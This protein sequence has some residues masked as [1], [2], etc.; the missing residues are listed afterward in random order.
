MRGL[1]DRRRVLIIGWDGL[2]PD[3]ITPEVTPGLY[4]L[5]QRGAVAARHYAA[6]P[7]E[8]RV[9]AATLATGCWPGRHGIV[10]NEFY[11]RE[12]AS[13][14]NTGSHEHLALIT[15]Y[16]EPVQSAPTLSERLAEHGLKTGISSAGSPGSALMWDPKQIGPV[17]NVFVEFGDPHTREM[18][19]AL[20]PQPPRRTPNTPAD[21]YAARAVTE[22]YLP[23]EAMALCVLWLNDPDHSQHLCGLGSP[24]AVQSLRDCDGVLEEVLSAIRRRGE[25][26]RTDIIICSDHGFSTVVRERELAQLIEEEGLFAGLDDPIA[27]V[28]SYG[29]Y[30]REGADVKPVVERLQAAPWCGTLLARRPIGLEGLLPLGEAWNGHLNGRAPDL[31]VSPAWDEA[32]NEHGVCG[33][34]AFG[35]NAAN[36]GSISP[37]DLHSTLIAYGPSFRADFVSETP[38]GAADMAPTVLHLLGIPTDD[39]SPMDGRVLHELLIDSQA[40]PPS[41]LRRYVS[42]GTG[43][44]WQQLTIDVVGRSQYLVCGTA[45]R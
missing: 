35:S 9:N 3:L 16:G 1:H 36:H 31:I 4:R 33:H 41:H 12:A 7:T 2:R 28:A 10:G 25:T 27:A 19:D 34:A 40:G 5:A 37:F 23:Q 22:H 20:G 13:H 8:T 26:D 11:I 17:F 39:A 42:S 15:A 6:Y 29:I 21:F 44:A 43:A 32:P 38:C 14:I 18:R 45:Q 30:L 24:E